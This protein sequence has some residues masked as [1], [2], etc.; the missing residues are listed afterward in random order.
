MPHSRDVFSSSSKAYMLG[1][2]GSVNSP[3]RQEK[4]HMKKKP[5]TY[6]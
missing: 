5:D 3:T 6:L 4:G 1:N 2:A